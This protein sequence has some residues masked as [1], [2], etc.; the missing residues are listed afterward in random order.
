MNPAPNV[1]VAT[2][3]WAPLGSAFLTPRFGED[4]KP[5]RSTPHTKQLRNPASA[6][7]LVGA[8]LAGTGTLT[9]CNEVRGRHRIQEANALYREGNYKDAVAAF[10]DAEKLVPDLPVLWLNKGYTCR[11][12]IVPGTKTPESVAASTCALNAFKRY[13]ELKPTDERGDLLYLQTLFDSDEFEALASMYQ[14]RYKANPKDLE[15]VQGLMQVYTKWNKTEDALQWY[16]VA[17]DLRPTDAE[18][19]YAVGVFLYNQLQQK[20]GG[21]D[22][23]MYDP[24]VDPNAA[25][26]PKPKGKGK[27]PAPA[28]KVAPSFA[29]GDIVGQQ[30]V[31]YADEGIKYLEKAVA[32][33]PQYTDAMVYLNLLYR[34]KSFAFFDAP[35]E[36]QKAVDKAEEWKKR[37]GELLNA[38]KAGS[39][40]PA[41]KPP[42]EA[43]AD[44]AKAAAP[45]AAGGDAQEPTATPP[46]ATP[47]KGAKK[48]AHTAKG[49]RRGHK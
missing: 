12:L 37:T 44:P 35:A 28:A 5:L 47:A 7:L 2:R 13:K 30:R 41:A 9:G 26:A 3:P 49:G 18:A 40:A 39:G 43:A 4:V 25:A 19:Q 29:Y 11:Q 31:D 23:Q 10:E 32:L 42:G 34:Q 6:A 14:D 46:S 48:V 22:K 16:R 24:R 1:R 8:L 20:G 21:P 15:A 36:W 38:A 33:R 17:A 27:A 45:E